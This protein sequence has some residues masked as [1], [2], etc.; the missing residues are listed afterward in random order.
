LVRRDAVAK[1]GSAP[2]TAEDPL[3]FW[4]ISSIVTALRFWLR[5]I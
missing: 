1:N 4:V 5:S 2:G 3:Q